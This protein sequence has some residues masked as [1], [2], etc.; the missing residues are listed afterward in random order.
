MGNMCGGAPQSA[1]ETIQPSGGLKPRTITS[2]IDTPKPSGGD[3][4]WRKHVLH[5]EV[6]VKTVHAHTLRKFKTTDGSLPKAEPK[7]Y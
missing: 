4:A 5:D 2:E 7:P 1:S 3:E 6:L